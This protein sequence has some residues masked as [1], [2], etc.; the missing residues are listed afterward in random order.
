MR[1]LDLHLGRPLTR[2]ALTVVPIWNGAA[3]GARG[4]DLGLDA[5]TVGECPTASVAQLTVLNN[6]RRPALVLEG[7]VLDGGLQHRVATASTLVAAGVSQVLDVRCVE[8]G[9]WSGRG[10]HSRTG[11]RAPVS[12]RAA[13]DQGGTWERVGRFEQRYGRSGTGRRARRFLEQVTAL[14]TVAERS[15]DTTRVR[16]RSRHAQ[17]DVLVWRGRAVHA[18]A[19]DL[20]HELV[21]A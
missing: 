12:V 7:E 21:A 20:R 11:R 16:G 17:L 6:G 1:L 18:V 5:L 14:P 8:Q 2:G 10:T 19:V 4:Y 15:A 3:T 9:R 13:Q